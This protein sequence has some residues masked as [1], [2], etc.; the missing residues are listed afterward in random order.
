M[1][2]TAELAPVFAHSEE[3]DS[4]TFRGERYTLQ[5]RQAAV[6]KLLHEALKK[7]HPA[8]AGR[9]ILRVPGCEDVPSIRDIFKSRPQLWGSLVINCEGTSDGR[10]F[11]S[12]ASRH[13]SVVSSLIPP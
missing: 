10:G 12:V 4:I 7:G 2:K 3:Y 5:P 11:L 6:V 9:T 8:V 1:E 13:H